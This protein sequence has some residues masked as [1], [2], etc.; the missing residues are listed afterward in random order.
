MD[1][2]DPRFVRRISSQSSTEMARRT[3]SEVSYRI[4]EGF[5]DE[6]AQNILSHPIYTTANQALRQFLQDEGHT[7]MYPFVRIVHLPSDKLEQ[8]LNLE[9]MIS[10]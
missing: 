6:F 2:D 3:I 5:D 1:F 9:L 7:S 10:A 4:I 8:S